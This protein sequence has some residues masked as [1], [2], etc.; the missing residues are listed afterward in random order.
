MLKQKYERNS[1][2]LIIRNATIHWPVMEVLS[3]DWIKELYIDYEDKVN[4]SVKIYH[5]LIKCL[6]LDT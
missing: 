1:R 5:N 3:F 4:G 6:L 2:P